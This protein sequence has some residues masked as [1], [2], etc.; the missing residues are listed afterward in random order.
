MQI[1]V[2]HL[3]QCPF[4]VNA[5]RR[6][7][8]QLPSP[9]PKPG[10]LMMTINGRNMAITMLP[11]TTARKIIMTGSSSN[12]MAVIWVLWFSTARW[13][14]T[15]V[16]FDWKI[17]RCPDMTLRAGG[18]NFQL[19]WEE[20]SLLVLPA[21]EHNLCPQLSGKTCATSFNQGF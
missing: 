7:T 1:Y 10:S 2:R 18:L 4:I 14:K 17:W 20:R 15:Q 5:G 8:P 16:T 11:T 6:E 13:D 3:Q 21:K 12:V 9:P 19:A